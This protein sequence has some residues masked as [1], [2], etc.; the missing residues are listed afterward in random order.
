MSRWLSAAMLTSLG[1]FV[2]LSPWPAALA[3]G[4]CRS[5]KG[6]SPVARACQEGG[7]IGAKQAMRKL[8]RDAKAGGATFECGDCHPDDNSYDR[9]APDARDKFGRLLAAARRS[10]GQRSAVSR[11]ALELMAVQ[12][13]LEFASSPDT[14]TSPKRER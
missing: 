6:D 8:V 3:Q 5:A 2:A 13:P 14:A 7:L 4:G 12:L 9:L 10:S 11:T 1:A